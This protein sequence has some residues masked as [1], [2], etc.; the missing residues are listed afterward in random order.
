MPHCVAGLDSEALTLKGPGKL[1]S[2][3]RIA[4]N[5][6]RTP[7]FHSSG[8]CYIFIDRLP[9]VALYPQGKTKLYQQ[10]WPSIYLYGNEIERYKIHLSELKHGSNL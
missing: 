3:L 2:I 1:Y 4:L 7:E 6:F 5:P 10:R 9:D 8:R